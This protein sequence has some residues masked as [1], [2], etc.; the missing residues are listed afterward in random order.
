MRRPIAAR[1]AHWAKNAAR[2]LAR[3]G[4]RPN[5]V[6]L[7]SVAFAALAMACLIAAPRVHGRWTEV[8]LFCG[9][10]LC[11]QGRLL[12]NLFDGML[13]VEWDQASALGPIFNDFPD[14][15]ADV[16]ILAGCGFCGGPAWM[17]LAAWLAASLALVTAYTRV[18]GVAIGAHEYFVGPMAKPHRMATT[19]IACV[20]AALEA[21][22]G[23]TPRAMAIALAIIAL[24][25]VLT[26]A[27]RLKLIAR[28][29]EN[30]ARHHASKT[31]TPNL[32]APS[33]SAPSIETQ[34]VGAHDDASQSE[35]SQS[36]A[37]RKGAWRR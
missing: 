10:A 33:V 31:A 22:L 19:T 25:C 34:S 7:A 5:T 14:R 6:S 11:I 23:W 9:A 28:D 16:L 15:P 35:A 4:V 29:L 24:G 18:L 13:A 3:R 20:L 32:S 36:E 37:S 12:C 21:A 26:I 2:F 1:E 30:A 17:P 27:R 8:A